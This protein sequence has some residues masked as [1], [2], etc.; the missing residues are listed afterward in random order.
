MELP[1]GSGS[2]RV[3]LV[4][5]LDLGLLHDPLHHLAGD[6]L[7][8]AP[9]LLARSTRTACHAN[10]SGPADR[11]EQQTA[12]LDDAERGPA[13]SLIVIILIVIVVL[14]LLGF[15]GRGRF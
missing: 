14:A 13:L 10:L 12:I 4:G 1:D 6:A 7:F 5:R 2:K 11:A 8:V 3:P 9:R 15:F